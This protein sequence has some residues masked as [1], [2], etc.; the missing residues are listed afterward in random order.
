MGSELSDLFAEHSK[1]PSRQ[2]RRGDSAEE[3]YSAE[4]SKWSLATPAAPTIDELCPMAGTVGIE[5]VPQSLVTIS[6]SQGI[7]PSS[8]QVSEAQTVSHGQHDDP[9]GARSASKPDQAHQDAVESSGSEHAVLI[10]DSEDAHLKA[11]A[12]QKHSKQ[13]A[14]V[15]DRQRVWYKE[16]QVQLTI[17]GY[18]FH[19][20][21]SHC[22][23]T[24]VIYSAAVTSI[25]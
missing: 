18:D 23:C 11:A 3:M 20:P 9:Q 4:P 5:L 8:G 16:R 6:A 22:F 17:L 19:S 24:R 2:V 13:E 10:A 21:S 25:S 14:A 7:S 12:E 15:A 1:K